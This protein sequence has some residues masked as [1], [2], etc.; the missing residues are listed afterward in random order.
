M[1]IVFSNHINNIK[2]MTTYFKD[3]NNKLKKKYKKFKTITTILK[4]FGTLVI[5]TT[6]S[7]SITLSLTG[8]GFIAIPI[9]TATAC[10]LS[11]GNKVIYEIII[12]KYKKLKKQFERDQRTIKSFDK[13]YRKSLQDNVIDKNEYE[14]LCKIFT[15]YVDE[16]KNESFL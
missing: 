4:S 11:I 13:L 14:S 1:L 7:S 3:K 8:I 2:E 12:N 15:K 6:T 16:N 10:G 5:I 9:S